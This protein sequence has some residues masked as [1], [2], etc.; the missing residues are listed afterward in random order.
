[1]G[2]KV[3]RRGAGD[4]REDPRRRA[5]IVR[6]EGDEA[7]TMRKIAEKIDYSATAL[8]THF[9]DKES[10]LRELCDADFLALRHAFDEDRRGSPTRSNGCGRWGGPTS[11]SRCE[12]PNHYR[13]MFMT[14]HPE[15]APDRERGRAGQPRPGRLRL[16][17]SDGRRGAWRRGG[18]ARSRRRRP[19]AQVVW[20]GVHGVVVAPHGQGQRPLARLA[21]GRGDGA[22]L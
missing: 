12:Y 6:D 10:L 19:V 16:P 18:S 11:R 5:R 4:A 22:G 7:V 17:A 21:A 3:G 15:Q 8:Y 1:M 14:P 9:A 2:S 13:L 20:S